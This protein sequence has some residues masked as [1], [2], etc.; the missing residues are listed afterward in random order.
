MW[1]NSAVGSSMPYLRAQHTLGTRTK[2]I[3][4]ATLSLQM[5]KN[6]NNCG[7]LVQRFALS[8]NIFYQIATDK[9][10]TYNPNDSRELHCY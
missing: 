6:V 5:F 8:H 3:I 7:T 1:Y 9:L 2:E 10:Q 4:T